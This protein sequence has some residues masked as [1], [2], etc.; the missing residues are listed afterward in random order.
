M[1]Y[2]PDILHAE[3]SEMFAD[4]AEM[5]VYDLQL[6]EAELLAE[7]LSIIV[8]RVARRR[9][10]ACPKSRP[11]SCLWCGGQIP[12]VPGVQQTR[13]RLYC[14]D[15]HKFHAFRARSRRKHP[16]TQHLRKTGQI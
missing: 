6:T 9:A 7:S 5:T 3:V 1:S 12:E 4:M 10:H 14:C 8:T 15:A 13:P 2:R 11:S 16:L